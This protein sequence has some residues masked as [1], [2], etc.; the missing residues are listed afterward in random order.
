MRVRF[1][2]VCGSVLVFAALATSAQESGE[3]DGN[4]LPT[5]PL[6]EEEPRS[7]ARPRPVVLEEIVVTA[8]KRVQSLADVPVSVTAVSREKLEAA[9]I[10]NLTDLS[11]YTPNFKLVDSGLIP[12]VYMRGVGS[13]SNQGFELS[14]GIF[15]D[16]I[17]LGRPHQT[18]AAF[19]DVERVE[20]LRGPQSTLFGKNAIAGA[21]NIVSAGPGDHYEG[22]LS[23]S[24]ELENGA[25]EIFAMASGPVTS[26]LGARLAVR[27]R[28]EDGDLG[29]ATQERTEP[30]VQ[31]QSARL[32]VQWD[33]W[34]DGDHVLKLEHTRRDQ[35]GRRFQTTH[36][37]SLT[38][39]TGEDV[40]LDR[41]RVTDAREDARI[42]SYNATARAT[43][44]VFGGDLTA[45]T[46]LSGF[47]SRDLF[48][49]DSSSLD[50]LALLGVEKYDQFS[51]ELRFAS[52]PGGFFDY[53]GGL[54]YQRGAL[55]FFE[56][57]PTRARAGALADSPSC[58]ANLQV[59]AEADLER[60]F[61]IDSEAWSVFAQGTLSFHPAW[62]A[63]FGL[64]YVYE[65]KQGYRDFRIYEPGTQ[66]P[67]NP[68]S[69]AALD[70]LLI[71]EHTLKRSRSVG[72]LLPHLNLQHDLTDR[73]MAYFTATR[74]AKSGSYDARNNN[75]NT[76]AQGGA[77]RF[78]F[79]D[80][81]A[82][83]LELGAKLGL[84]GGRADLNLAAFHVRYEDMQVSVYDGVAGF[85]VANAGSALTQGVE[86]DGRWL[87]PGGLRFTA[88]I[89]YLDFEWLD[90]KDGPCHVNSTN[91]DS[92]TDTCDLTGR[93]NLQTPRW[94]GAIAADY[95]TGWGADWNLDFGVDVS[96]RDAYFSSGDLDPRGIQDAHA[97]INARMA[98]R[99]VDDSWEMALIGKNLSDEQTIAVG[100]PTALDIGGYR[101][102]TE[103]TRTVTVEVRYHF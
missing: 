20:V 49:A 98:V 73:A 53:I 89:A 44:P 19:M 45:V 60:D 100:A 81:I 1:A 78:E 74:G 92:Q 18:R 9:G 97:K 77:T 62:R 34:A 50:T 42:D 90:Y 12:N 11:E 3:D 39:C 59:L 67:A 40:R 30:G 14:V 57:G 99:P 75:G 24:L 10:E 72:V 33:G 27:H 51:Q 83:A 84:L 28:S 2:G 22:Q 80:E 43:Y 13:G 29:N 47:D 85:T 26:T 31:E 103:N 63:T 6:P 46:G 5:I 37:G 82:D 71:N 65:H 68:A 4:S 17:H 23:S 7:A 66:D 38:R 96:F 69:T 21:I 88:S 64:R 16:G 48:D 61:T 95:S 94:T 32:T 102:A 41:N 101:V 35:G 55:D 86:L 87:L 58:A 54:F 56:F 36:P 93:Q 8:Q 25:S 76:D 91:R 52:A 15:A 70:Q 79:D